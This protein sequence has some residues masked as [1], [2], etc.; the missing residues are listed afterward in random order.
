MLSFSCELPNI[1]GT[2]VKEEKTQIGTVYLCVIFI[3]RLIDLT[4]HI[5]PSPSLF[6][7]IQWSSKKENIALG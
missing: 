3:V 4:S 1:T 2:W 5:G 7:S 6:K